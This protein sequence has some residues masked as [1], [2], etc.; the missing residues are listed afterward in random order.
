MEEE[1]VMGVC[2]RGVFGVS[3]TG[4]WWSV[5]KGLNG[6]TTGSPEVRV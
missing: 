2:D 1:P 4:L 6:S 5:I 3:H